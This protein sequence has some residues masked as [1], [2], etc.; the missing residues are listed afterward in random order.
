MKTLLLFLGLAFAANLCAQQDSLVSYTNNAGDIVPEAYAKKKRVFHKKD[1]VYWECHEYNAKTG[2]LTARYTCRTVLPIV[3][4]GEYLK[5][6]DTTVVA[7]YHYKNNKKEGVAKEY[8]HSGML[9]SEGSYVGDSM[10]GPWKYYY[11]NG[12]L[13][14]ELEYADNKLLGGYYYNPDGTKSNKKVSDG[15]MPTYAG[16]DY[17]IMEY[18]KKEVRY[19]NKMREADMSGIVYVEF[20]VDTNGSVTEERIAFSSHSGFNEEALRVIRGMDKWKPGVQHMEKVSVRYT[21]PIKFV[22][23]GEE[24]SKAQKSYKAGQAYFG[25]HDYEKA[26][27]AFEASFGLDMKYWNALLYKALSALKLGR[28]EE[29]CSCLKYLKSNAPALTP[30]EY[31]YCR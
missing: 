4:E 13:M 5:H 15:E 6:E 14:A 3:I 9:K 2:K 8:R 17:G 24:K 11:A 7:E 18:L 1:D 23:S 28:V 29:A 30:P 22:L 19:P 12:A 27:Q 16:G 21:V 20:V 25:Q 10:N 26:Y 31:K